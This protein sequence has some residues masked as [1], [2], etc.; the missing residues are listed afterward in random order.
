MGRIARAAG[1][2]AC[3][4]A[5]AGGRRQ[6]LDAVER[7]VGSS[8]IG[9]LRR[10]AWLG[11]ERRRLHRARRRD[12]GRGT[13]AGRFGRIG[14]RR[15][16]RSL[17]RRVLDSPFAV[18]PATAPTSSPNAQGRDVR[19]GRPRLGP[20]ASAVG[21]TPGAPIR[22]VETM[23]GH[24]TVG[25]IALDRAGD[26]A[27]GT[28]TGG[29]PYKP[30]GRVGTRRSSVPGCRT[31]CPVRLDERSRRTDHPRRPIQDCR[32]P[33]GRRTRPA[34]RRRTGTCDATGQGTRW[35]DPWSTGQ[36]RHR[37]EHAGDGIR[38]TAR[39]R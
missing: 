28:S 21:G 25:A 33:D 34:G 22:W 13:A 14:A 2:G 18:L 39:R 4:L 36:D 15:P 27:A 19:S 3:R 9:H 32:R 5:G 29:M 8:R 23:F 26:L 17:A 1:C 30:A 16:T 20:R 7:A 6:R 11:L 38:P 24:D 10:R 35:P 31:T 12:D 37:L